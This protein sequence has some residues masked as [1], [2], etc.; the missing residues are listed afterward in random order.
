MEI[1]K[2]LNEFLLTPDN[3]IVIGSGILNVLGLRQ[4]KDI[5]LIV[6]KEKFRELSVSGQFLEKLNHGRKILVKGL[7]KIGT[8][9]RVIEK[10]WLFSDLL[11]QSEVIKG[12]RYNSIKFLFKVKSNWCQKGEAR[13]KD[14]RDLKLMKSYL[15]KQ[16]IN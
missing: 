11:L 14:L 16:G 15:G 10:R 13:Q 5:D 4:S 7:F 3:S 12:V 8:S 1:K 6:T 9:W 2:R